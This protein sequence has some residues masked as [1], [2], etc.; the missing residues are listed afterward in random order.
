MKISLPQARIGR[1]G[2][3]L[4][5]VIL[6]LGIS[7]LM[8]AGMYTYAKSNERLNQRNNDYM[9]ATTAAEAATEKVLA[10]ITSDFR[11]F[12]D[13]YLQQNIATYR[14]M[15]PTSAEIPTATNFDFQ[16]LSG[17]SGHLDVQ[18]NSLNGFSIIGSQYG[19]LH[20]FNDQ[21]RIIANAKS[22]TS[23]DGVAASVYQDINLTRIPIFQYAIFYNVPLEFTPLPPMFVTGL[24]HCN[25]NIYMNPAGSL[26]FNSDVTATGTIYQGINPI[27]PMP[28]LGGTVTYNGA[29]DSGTSYL[30]LPI[31]TNSSA[32]AVQQILA[33]PPPLEDPLSAIGQE[34]FYNKADL[35]ILVSN[36]TVVAESGRSTSFAYQVPTNELF[37]FVSTN[38][39]FYNKREGKTVAAIQIDVAKLVQWNATNTSIRPYLPNGD[40]ATIYVSDQRSLPSTSESGVRLVNGSTLPPSGLTVATPSPA[41]IL[42]NYNVPTSAIGTTNT[43][44]TLPASVASDA[45]TI[46]STA[47]NDANSSRS[48]SYRIAGNT[49]VNAAFL[50]GI[51]AS[52]GAS[53]SGGVENYPRFLEDW[54]GYTFTYNG[55]LVCMYYS[56]IATGLWLGIGSQYDIYNPPNR[57]WAWDQNFQYR[58]KLPPSTPCLT[59]LVRAE[60]R[61][62]AAF[63]TNT[64]A[65]F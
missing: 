50:T 49:T 1:S 58:N 65:G 60:W 21:I 14:A 23:L 26:T 6:L 42:G 61:M 8:V 27:S 43:T 3:V 36:N 28:A 9:S 10:Q 25:T 30:N 13:G 63:T 52:T 45:I 5:T 46:L 44:G 4:L 2:N 51:V 7:G 64:I 35:V 18:F 55:S 22:K 59:V 17:N 24:V 38:T 48:L 32:A 16:D 29:H 62:P 20:G 37:T 11:N 15:V 12:G 40:V 34:R 54:T 56:A 39:S 47:W 57:N 41:Y 31:G 19:P 33:L 53:D